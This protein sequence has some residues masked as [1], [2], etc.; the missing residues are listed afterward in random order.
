[1]FDN[2][3]NYS[4]IHFIRLHILFFFVKIISVEISVLCSNALEVIEFVSFVN[5]EREREREQETITRKKLDG[6][7]NAIQIINR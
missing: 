7:N 4:Y 6:M 5:L 3:V 1:M 2:E